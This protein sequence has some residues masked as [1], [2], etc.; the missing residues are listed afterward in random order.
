MLI[1][2][3]YRKV[4]LQHFFGT[5]LSF[6][7]FCEFLKHCHMIMR[8]IILFHACLQKSILHNS[9]MCLIMQK[10]IPN[11]LQKHIYSARNNFEIFGGQ[12]DHQILNFAGHCKILAVIAIFVFRKKHRGYGGCPPSCLEYRLK[13]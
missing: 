13:T 11:L 4:E 3:G 1:S 9:K 7:S 6:F 8:H 5:S 2:I 10:N 12:H